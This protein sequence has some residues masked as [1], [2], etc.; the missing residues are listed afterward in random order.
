MKQCKI[1]V[2]GALKYREIYELLLLGSIY[3]KVVGVFS[4]GIMRFK[5]CIVLLAFVLSGCS[6]AIAPYR[7]SN[8]ISPYE[9]GLQKAK[10]GEERYE[11]LLK[12]HKEA[13][14]RGMTVD[15]HGI[16]DI[17][18][19]IPSNAESIPL[20]AENEFAGVIFNVTNKSQ[21]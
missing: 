20:G 9:F 16:K 8:N 14:R 4:L 15:Y 1:C 11:V 12:T 17:N 3:Y 5:I 2:D 6:T 19:T 13:I 10:T 18:L 7:Y 21:N